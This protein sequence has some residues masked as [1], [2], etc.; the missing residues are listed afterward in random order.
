[1]SPHAR[2]TRPFA[3]EVKFVVGAEVGSQIRS[4]IRA[5]LEPDPHGGGLFDDEYRTT[6]LYFDTAL[7]D[8]FSP[9]AHSAAASTASQVRHGIVRLPERKLRKPGILVKRARRSTSKRSIGCQ[10]PGRIRIGR[11]LVSPTAA[12]PPDQAV[13]QVSYSRTA[14]FARTPEGPVRLTLDEDVRVRAG[15]TTRFSGMVTTRV[16]GQMILELKYR[17]HVPAIFKRLVEEFA[18]EPE[19]VSKYRVGMTVLGAVDPRCR[20]RRGQR[21]PCLNRSRRCST[22]IPARSCYLRAARARMAARSCDR[23]DSTGRARR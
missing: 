10:I 1:M 6:S 7:G 4:W 8:V 9:A 23:G 2:E 17:Q 22:S 12:S 15:S 18:L 19:R 5:N 21:S 11:R 20:L 16:P 3:S 14:R 13:C